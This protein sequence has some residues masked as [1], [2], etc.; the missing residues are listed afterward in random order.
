MNQA[1]LFGNV[2]EGHGPGSR[3]AK[4]ELRKAKRER[5]DQ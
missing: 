5:D 4:C 3:R 1:G 2:G